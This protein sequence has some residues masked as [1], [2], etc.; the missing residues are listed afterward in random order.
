MEPKA[1]ATSSDKPAPFM[2]VGVLGRPGAG[3]GTQCQWLSRMFA[4][5]H[6][7]IGDVLRAEME[8]EGSPYAATIRQNMLAGTV[9]PKEVTIPIL[10]SHI[11][12]ASDAGVKVFV[13]DGKRPGR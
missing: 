2:L 6:I 1:E 12:A 9:G 7:S 10:K 13:V 8:R 3:K 11:M 4:V 5:E